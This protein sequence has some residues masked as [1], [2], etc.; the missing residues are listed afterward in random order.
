LRIGKGVRVMARL[1]GMILALGVATATLAACADTTP[2]PSASAAA[3][4]TCTAQGD[5]TYNALDEDQL[6]RTSQSGL[7]FSPMPN[8]V[9]DAEQEGAMHVR[10]S[11][12]ADCERNGTAPVGQAAAAGTLSGNIVTPHIVQTP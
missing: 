2:E 6:A 11:Q 7:L 8:H 1:I 9:F 10:D 12:I 4:A 5:A 3:D